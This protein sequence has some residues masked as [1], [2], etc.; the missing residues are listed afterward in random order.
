MIKIS[1]LGSGCATCK[2]LHSTVAKVVSDN[3]IDAEVEYSTD[4]SRIIELGLM[5]SPVLVVAGKPVQL[6]SHKDDAV[7][8]AIYENIN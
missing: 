4:V 2:K 6:N 1:V 3:K 8:N 7:L 5:Y